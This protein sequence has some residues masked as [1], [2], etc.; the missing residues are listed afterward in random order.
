MGNTSF[1]IPTVEQVKMFM[2]EKKPA[3]PQAFCLYYAE[4]FWHSYNSKGWQIANNKRMKSWESAFFAQ[5][6]EVK[7]QDDLNVLE[8]AKRLGALEKQQRQQIATFGAP[9]SSI[10][11]DKTIEYLDHL[12]GEYKRHPTSIPPLRLAS[13]YDFLKT[14]KLIRINADQRQSAIM[15]SEKDGIEAGKA[16]IVKIVFDSMAMQMVSFS[17]LLGVRS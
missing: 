14:N 9:I 12:L 10:P 7:Y 11:E 2:Q 3:W 13:C 1:E 4:K 8:G 6:Q 17:E 15:A 5:W 16:V